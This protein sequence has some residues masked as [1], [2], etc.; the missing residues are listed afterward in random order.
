M[1]GV[2]KI[3]TVN[4]TLFSSELGCRRPTAMHRTDLDRQITAITK[5]V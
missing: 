3:G 1:F 2:G 4:A 5:K